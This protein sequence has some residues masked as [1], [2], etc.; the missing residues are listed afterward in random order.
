[1]KEKRGMDVRI[2]PLIKEVTNKQL[3]PDIKLY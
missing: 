3:K 1:M 2:N